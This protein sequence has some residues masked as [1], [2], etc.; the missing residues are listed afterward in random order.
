[1]G[2]PH[3]SEANCCITVQSIVLPQMKGCWAA[4]EDGMLL[5]KDLKI[6]W[7]IL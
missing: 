7:N 6:L 4:Y 1:M 2:L 3:T 5:Y